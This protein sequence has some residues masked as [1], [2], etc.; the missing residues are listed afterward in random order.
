MQHEV[1]KTLAPEDEGTPLLVSR[2]QLFRAAEGIIKQDQAE[3][4]WSRLRL[5]A[6]ASNQISS[7]ANVLYYLGG[8]LVIASFSFL[9][10]TFWHMPRVILA[11]S[12]SFEALI[13]VLAGKLWSRPGLRTP[14]GLLYTGV[15]CLVPVVVLSL[16]RCV[17]GYPL[18]EYDSLDDYAKHSYIWIGLATAVVGMWLLQSVDFPFLVAPVVLN[19]YVLAFDAVSVANCGGCETHL[20]EA[21][22]VITLLVALKLDGRSQD[23]SFWL[24]IL[25]LAMAWPA[26]S[27]EILDARHWWFFCFCNLLLMAVSVVLD[28]TVFLIFGA[29]GVTWFLAHLFDDIFRHSPFFPV[30]VAVAGLGVMASGHLLNTQGDRVRHWAREFLPRSLPAGQGSSEYR[31]FQQH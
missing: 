5:H 8:L 10:S 9:Q 16:Q 26:T 6:A 23:L 13:F 24:Y 1:V 27:S 17:G 21:L 22:G 3:E 25:G 30:A 12:V 31:A 29:V 18:G 19:F 20:T 7:G 14:G 11:M 15:V 28:R 2:D 4:L